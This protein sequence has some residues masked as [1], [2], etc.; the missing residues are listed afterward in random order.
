M[1]NN[2]SSLAISQK[3]LRAIRDA[4]FNEMTPIQA[5]SIPTLLAGKDLIGQSQTGSGKTAAFII[6]ILQNI[7][8]SIMAV[9]ALILCPTRELSDQVL[10]E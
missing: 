1:T 3:L 4:G 2:F 8:V 5:A 9:Q 10:H 6:P 7:D